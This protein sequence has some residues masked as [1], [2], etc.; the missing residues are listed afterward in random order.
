MG[1]GG[2]H[3]KLGGKGNA[4]GITKIYLFTTQVILTQSK[5][6]SSVMFNESYRC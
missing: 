1:Y 5:I 3:P 2:I 6:L 4:V